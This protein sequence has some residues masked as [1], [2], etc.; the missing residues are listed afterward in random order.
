MSLPHV[1]GL[2]L[3]IVLDLSGRTV[4]EYAS[5]VEHGDAID[6]TKEAA[7][8]A[9]ELE[10]SFAA[11]FHEFTRLDLTGNRIYRAVLSFDTGEEG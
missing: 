11:V 8:E 9:D 7:A 1:D 4:L 10:A 5:V 2:H 6:D 3:R